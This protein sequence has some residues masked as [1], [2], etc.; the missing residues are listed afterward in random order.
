MIPVQA[1]T[2]EYLTRR[3]LEL[4]DG[5]RAHQKGAAPMKF[6][7]AGFTD[8]TCAHVID[9]VFQLLKKPTGSR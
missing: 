8:P 5:Q 1:V 6:D 7:E 3:A 4:E 2:S 9:M